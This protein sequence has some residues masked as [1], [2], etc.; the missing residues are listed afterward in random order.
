MLTDSHLTP[1]TN[2]RP[3]FTSMNVQ[4][5]TRTFTSSGKGIYVNFHTVVCAR[6]RVEHIDR[7]PTHKLKGVSY[8]AFDVLVL[9]PKGDCINLPVAFL[10]IARHSHFLIY[11]LA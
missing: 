11:K 1:F 6:Q 4:C 10:F 3:E 2:E 8:D 9:K 5:L 7:K